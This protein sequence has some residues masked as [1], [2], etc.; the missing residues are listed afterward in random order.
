MI[1]GVLAILKSYCDQPPMF[2]L[3][4]LSLI[5]S[6]EYSS[7]YSDLNFSRACSPSSAFTRSAT[8]FLGSYLLFFSF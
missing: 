7:F 3:Y 8:S 6:E 4:S 5:R 1:T 2:F